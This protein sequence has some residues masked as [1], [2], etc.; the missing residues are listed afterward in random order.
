VTPDRTY[1]VVV[2]I[3]QYQLDRADL[4][5]PSGDAV[6][7]VAWL[8][9]NGVPAKHIF[10]FLSPLEKNAAE[11]DAKLTSPEIGVRRKPARRVEIE[12]CLEALGN[13]QY[14]GDLLYLFWGGHGIADEHGRYLFYADTTENTLEHHLHVA[15]WLGRLGSYGN[16][17]RQIGYI[18][19]CANF[20]PTWKLGKR[21]L[22]PRQSNAKQSIF[23]A[24]A[25]GQRA[26]NIE[27]VTSGKFSQSL[28]DALAEVQANDHT[29]PPPAGDVIKA[30]RAR[31]SSD[32]T[33]TPVLYDAGDFEGNRWSDGSVRELKF[34]AFVEAVAQQTGY[35]VTDLRNWAEEATRSEKLGDRATREKAQAC[36]EHKAKRGDLGS[37]I[38]DGFEDW[39]RMIA[40]AIHLGLLQ[41]LR[42]F[43]GAADVYAVPLTLKMKITPDLKELERLLQLAKRTGPGVPPAKLTD[44]DLQEAFLRTLGAQTSRESPPRSI[45]EMLRALPLSTD[46][47]LRKVVEFVLRL[48]TKAQIGELQRWAARNV[49]PDTLVEIQGRLDEELA[50]QIYY[51]WCWI[52]NGQFAAVLYRGARFEFVTKWPPATFVGR[53]LDSLIE[54]HLKLAEEYSQKLVIHFLVS[55]DFFDWSPQSVLVS[56]ALDPEPLGS[57][58]PTVMRWRERALGLARTGHEVWSLRAPQ[59]LECAQ[60]CDKLTVGWISE[61]LNVSGLNELL[62]AV[63]S[64]HNI[65]AFDFAAPRTIREP[66]N[67]VIAAIRGGIPIILW[68]CDDPQD[69]VTIRNALANSAGGSDLKRLLTQ[70]QAFYQQDAS[71]W[72]VTLFWDDPAHKPQKWEYS[73][74]L[75]K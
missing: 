24:A 55:R 13:A 5:G 43:I 18:D 6:Q 19:T 60:A 44:G 62:K 21:E 16:L 25:I 3:E 7:F 38:A 30:L 37:T 57:T 1:A 58:Y 35:S 61:K 53:S 63:G 66:G 12:E 28:R 74:D 50:D 11:L 36:L 14:T 8:R 51:L 4:N 20:K 39:L 34:L 49:R 15:S 46:D 26:A 23:F 69:P 29:W 59:V 42:E 56:S 48:N 54:Q 32:R 9:Q 72:K 73:D 31:F 65:L 47:N 22:A 70:M 64:Q 45:D 10:L 2:G 52:Q 17:P 75:G 67:P 33:Q 40:L 71:R 27:A 41:A 68:P